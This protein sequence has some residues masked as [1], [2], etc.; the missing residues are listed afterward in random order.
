[1]HLHSRGTAG[2][3]P[4][5][6]SRQPSPRERGAP[7]GAVLRLS[8]ALAALGLALSLTGCARSCGQAV[9]PATATSQPTAQSVTPTPQPLAAVAT[10]PPT[11]TVT[12]SPSATPTYPPPHTPTSTATPSPRPT[13]TATRTPTAA[14][15]LTPTAPSGPSLYTTRR[16]LG[17]AFSSGYGPIAAYPLDRL[18]FGWYLDWQ[19]HEHPAPPAGIEFVQ[20]V[21]TG[22]GSYPPDWGALRRA[23]AANPGSLWLVGNEPECLH[24]DGRA[25]EDYAAIYHDVYAALKAADPTAQVAIGGVVE[26]TPLRLE[27]L[28]RVLAAYAAAYGEPLP[29]DAWNT[30]NQILQELRGEY[31]CDIPV[32]LAADA[33]MRYAYDEND[34]LEHFRAHIWA[35]RHWM[36][37]H[38]YRDRPLIVSEFGVLMPR[39]LL[40][41]EGQ[42][43]SGEARV[44]AFMQGSIGWMLSASDPAIGCP[45][46]GNRLVQRWAWF[47]LNGPNWE[48]EPAAN[49][50]FNGGL[51]HPNTRALTVYGEAYSHLAIGWLA[52]QP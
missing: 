7:L 9:P 45:A 26:P 50:G 24:Q 43:G 1:M 37:Q 46:D 17:V 30:H 39:A 13:S 34:S 3:A 6:R 27:W 38:G 12:T 41:R 36:A 16:R 10:L 23:A 51:S 44:M 21:R 25:P 2:R 33:G 4:T 40:E 31:G 48:D 35:L 49:Q 29:V 5:Q 32:G 14:P 19:F 20:T 15:T 18:P 47:S 42:P 28:D 11:A 22:P 8:L 52:G